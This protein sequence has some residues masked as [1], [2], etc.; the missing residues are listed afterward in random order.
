M[1]NR[2]EEMLELLKLDFE[3]MLKKNS[4]EML[5]KMEQNKDKIKVDF[6]SIINKLNAKVLNHNKKIK[7]FLISPL[8]SSIIT[9]SFEIQ[10][11]MYTKEFYLQKEE[12]IEYFKIPFLFDNINNDMI[13]FEKKLKSNFTRLEKFEIKEIKQEYMKYHQS[14]IILF[15]IYIIK[16]IIDIESL[17]NIKD[18]KLTFIYGMYM[19]STIELFSI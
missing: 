1:F 9:E 2:K 14:L 7:Y 11:A 4:V 5:E 10:L 6:L 3:E 8:Q 12:Y 13:C 19:D 15:V 17:Q 18:D 16:Y